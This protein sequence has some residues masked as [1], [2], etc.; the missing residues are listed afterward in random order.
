MVCA[1]VS[2]QL[3]GAVRELMMNR[4]EIK[5]SLSVEAAMM[6]RLMNLPAN[7]FRQYA[8]GELSSRFG[9]VNQ[10][11]KLLVGNVFSTG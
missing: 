3:I 7:F 11:C 4:I 10:L 9:A 1:I 5:T 8:S 6:M 2:S